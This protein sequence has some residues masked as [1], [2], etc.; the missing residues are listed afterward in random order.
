MNN[1]RHVPESDHLDMDWLLAC[2]RLL[3]IF[4]TA[5]G[6][7]GLYVLRTWVS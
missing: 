2:D 1:V 6:V 4:S 7:V 5:L 3:W